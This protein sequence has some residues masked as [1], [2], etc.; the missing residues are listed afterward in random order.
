MFIPIIIAMSASQNV[1]HAIS[2]GAI[3]I[4]AGLA[5]VAA[6]FV[7]V[8]VLNLMS[9]NSTSNKAEKEE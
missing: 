2:S 8:P 6:A 9:K 3:A 5:A 4:V 1:Y 7:L